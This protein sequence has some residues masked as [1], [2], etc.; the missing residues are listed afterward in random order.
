MFGILTIVYILVLLGNA[1]CILN[2]ERFLNNLGIS[3]KSKYP[4]LQ[5][6]A[7]LIKTVKTVFIIPLIF[8]NSLFMVYEV[9]LG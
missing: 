4:A 5:Q 1:F 6:L 2:E 8:A 9:L 3:K 7:D